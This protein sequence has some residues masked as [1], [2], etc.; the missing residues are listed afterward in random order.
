VRVGVSRQSIHPGEE[1]KIM[2]KVTVD[3]KIAAPADEVWRLVGGWDALPEWHPA[4]ESSATE[5]GGRKRRLKLA[6]GAEI[7]EQLETFEGEAQSYTYSIVASSLP[8]TDYRSTITVRREGEMSTIEWST[9]FKPLGVPE[10]ELAEELEAF[11]K[12][13]F[14]NLRKLLRV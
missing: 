1:S 2:T 13:G 4:V 11:Y 14:D 9:T 6:D 3:T 10:T 5:D 7:T 8:L 12:L